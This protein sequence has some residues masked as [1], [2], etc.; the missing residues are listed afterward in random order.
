MEKSGPYSARCNT[1][2]GTL[3]YLVHALFILFV[4]NTVFQKM[5]YEKKWKYL[6]DY[7]HVEHVQITQSWSGDTSTP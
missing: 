6:R 7:F 1:G 2:G 4:F 5:L 3:K